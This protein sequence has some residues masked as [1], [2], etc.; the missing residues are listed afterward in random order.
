MDNPFNPGSG[1]M[2]PYLA[3]RDEEINK[4]SHML[5]DIKAG[6][7][8]NILMQGIRGMG[9][10]VLLNRF[11]EIC[12]TEGFL[13]IQRLQYS[14]QYSDP[15]EFF[16]AIRYDLDNTIQEFSK[17]E[18]TKGKIQSAASYLKPK[19][20][21]IPGV[22]SYE[23]SYNPD[24][25]APMEDQ[26]GDY[27]IKKS[28]FVQK[29]YEGVVFLLDEFHTIQNIKQ[30]GWYTLTAFIGAMN[31]VQTKGFRYSFVLCGLPTLSTNVKNARSYSE[32]MFKFLQISNLTKSA[33]REA[34][35][36]PLGKTGWSFSDDLVSL[37]ID[38]A[39]QYPFFIQYFA[40]ETIDR[41]DKHDIDLDDY[42]KVRSSIITNLGHDFFDQRME[43]L[44]DSM[45]K[46]L[47]SM[48]KVTETDMEFSSIHAL[49]NM[50]KGTLS[51]NL[52]RLNEKGVI[53]RHRHGTYR[54]SMPLFK[55][56][57]L[58]KNS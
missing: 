22:I 55:R 1:L 54:F 35:T 28:K 13:P 10:T 56:Y 25:N 48:A 30:N 8:V 6:K 17:L 51:K 16:N 41:I 40:K 3:G 37:I 34:I 42:E 38:D 49:S 20:I 14:E 32:R 24:F 58:E 23:P 12:T 33:S 21:E 47:Y 7:A 19:N 57:L 26:I 31:H 29:N 18:K 50:N 39:D 43:P 2:P 15:V 45:K 4:F 5:R 36:K 11:A 44:S 53:Y 9:K 27:L 52:T 46:L